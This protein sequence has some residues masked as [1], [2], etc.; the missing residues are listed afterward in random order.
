ML[1]MQADATQQQYHLFQLVRPQQSARIYQISSISMPDYTVKVKVKWIYIA[2]SR[3][4]S[5]A[6]RH[7]SHSVTCNYTYALPAFTS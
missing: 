6:L 7:G 3:E 5:K 2:P 4:T 1:Y